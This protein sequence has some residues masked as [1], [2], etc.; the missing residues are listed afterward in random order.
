VSDAGIHKEFMATTA[1]VAETLIVG[2]QT[3]LWLVLVV[4]TAFG[5]PAVGESPKGWEFVIGLYVVA[6]AYVLGVMFD[7]L[8][9]FVMRPL[10]NVFWGFI[11]H[12]GHRL[13]YMP[14]PVCLQ[15]VEDLRMAIRLKSEAIATE[16][17]DIR[18]PLRITRATALNLL[19]TT[20]LLIVGLATS[21]PQIVSGTFTGRLADF[22]TAFFLVAVAAYLTIEIQYYRRLVAA[23]RS[24]SATPV[25]QVVP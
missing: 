21:Q 9:A 11:Q 13:V 18:R 16:V 3:T 22:T 20:G 8:A 4:V 6:T 14:E 24:L 7:R 23:Q 25:G 19:V 15:R 5:I 17:D 10:E 12:R 1:L 2:L